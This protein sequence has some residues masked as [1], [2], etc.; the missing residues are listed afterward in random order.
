MRWRH[1]F[2]ENMKGDSKLLITAKQRS[3]FICFANILVRAE[4]GK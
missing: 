4:M 3:G 1:K 2:G